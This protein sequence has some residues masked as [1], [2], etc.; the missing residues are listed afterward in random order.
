M[1]V[2]FPHLTTLI[3]THVFPLAETA[4]PF[5]QRLCVPA[6]KGVDGALK[7]SY[8]LQPGICRVSSVDLVLQKCGFFPPGKPP[9]E[10]E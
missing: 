2:K 9:R 4:P 8:R 7:F 1:L 10:K 3:S 5:V 6:E